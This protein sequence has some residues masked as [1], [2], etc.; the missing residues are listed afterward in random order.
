MRART[1]GFSSLI[2]VLI[3]SIAIVIAALSQQL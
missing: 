1:V 3:A 2:I